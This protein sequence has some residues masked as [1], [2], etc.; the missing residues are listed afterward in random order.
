MWAAREEPWLN[1]EIRLH[2]LSMNLPM[3]LER[4]YLG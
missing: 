3:Y 2:P 1:F 4:I